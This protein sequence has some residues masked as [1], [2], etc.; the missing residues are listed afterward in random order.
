MNISMLKGLKYPDE[1]LIKFF[2]KKNL[3]SRRGNVL[4]LGC[5]NGS[6][7]ML[8]HAYGWNVRGVDISCESLADARHNFSMND[9]TK[10]DY[11]FIHHDLTSGIGEEIKNDHS[12]IDIVLLPSVLYYIPRSAAIKVLQELRERVNPGALV[13][14]RN[15]TKRDFRYRR[16]R[17]VDRN[18][19]QLSDPVTGEAGLLN[20]F[21]DEFEIVDMLR[22]NLGINMKTAEVLSI[23]SQNPQNGVR[24]FNSDICIWGEING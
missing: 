1:F 2:F 19:F 14:L 22:E 8:F 4:E 17:E 23:E 6:N 20:V 15:R 7:L 10:E 16:G 18:A 12:A 3:D 13:Y 24:V 9:S 21:Y 11:E 5:G